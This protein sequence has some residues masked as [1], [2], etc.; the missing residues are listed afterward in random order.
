MSCHVLDKGD[1]LSCTVRTHSP[2]Q[3]LS[4]SISRM[5][6]A[7]TTPG[8]AGS[9]PYA[10]PFHAHDKPRQELY[11]PSSLAPF[12][13]AA[14]KPSRHATRA[15]AVHPAATC[16]IFLPEHSSSHCLHTLSC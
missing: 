6:T 9:D 3:P 8:T 4:A 10:N 13:L 14:H 1:C 15:A 2:Y 11:N 5:N 7:F 12:Q 16:C